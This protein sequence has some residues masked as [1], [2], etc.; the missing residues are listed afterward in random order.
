MASI[1]TYQN[2]AQSLAKNVDLIN[3][4]S[5]SLG[6]QN[7]FK[8]G[9]QLN[10]ILKLL[11]YKENQLNAYEDALMA[12]FNP[13]KPGAV[14]R[15]YVNKETSKNENERTE[16]QS[17]RNRLTELS[18]AAGQS[19][20]AFARKKATNDFVAGMQQGQ[21][22]ETGFLANLIGVISN[23][24]KF[25]GKGQLVESTQD[26]ESFR[27]E[28]ENK[29]VARFEIPGINV[30]KEKQVEQQVEVNSPELVK[31]TEVQNSPGK[32]APGIMDLADELRESAAKRQG[33][34]TEQSVGAQ[35]N[36]PEPPPLPESM[37]KGPQPI[38][39]NQAEA[40]NSPGKK[41]PGIMDLADELRVKA[42]ARREKKA[43]S[44]DHN[45][46]QHVS[47]EP[48]V[49]KQSTGL[50]G[51]LQNNMKLDKGESQPLL[52]GVTKEKQMNVLYSA[53]VDGKK[54]LVEELLSHQSEQDTGRVD[55]EWEEPILEMANTFSSQDVDKIRAAV[56]E[57]QARV[58]RGEELPSKLAKQSVE[59]PQQEIITK[60]ELEAPVKETSKVHVESIP[61]PTSIRTSTPPIEK[62][63]VAPNTGGLLAEIQAGKKL[64]N[65]RSGNINVDG[66]EY[67]ETPKKSAMASALEGRR[68]AISGYSEALEE[69]LEDLPA[70][71]Q[72][73]QLYSAVIEGDKQKINAIIE[74]G[75]KDVFTTKDIE[76]VCVAVK[77]A[78]GN[79]SVPKKIIADKGVKDLAKAAGI[80]LQTEK[81]TARG[82]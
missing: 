19:T 45:D 16:I 68:G 31:A 71:K 78:V 62:E 7:A 44:L 47:T 28:L 79:L 15:D 76:R 35:S 5:G 52:D 33:V 77:K 63:T 12:E 75:D 80:E 9:G 2:L 67:T 70:K 81:S 60:S 8:E 14:T 40:Q 29:K 37:K 42:E 24:F 64:K 38:Q 57:T 34:E 73:N 6:L 1:E 56:S 23:A 66:F 46:Y 61:T 51:G 48:P 11:D 41:A 21:K 30:S 20:S 49:Q 13:G 59:K 22:V 36:I 18:E 43:V 53:M 50:L 69:M 72:L 27:A 54:E 4:R 39:Q 17:I 3:T 32:K 10:S 65:T 58:E 25:G 26:L 55:D 82:A 74:V